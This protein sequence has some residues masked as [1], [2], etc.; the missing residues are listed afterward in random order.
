MQKVRAV[1]LSS[2]LHS[3]DLDDFDDDEDAG[4]PFS[5]PDRIAVTL[6]EDVARDETALAELAPE[7][8]SGEGTRL[9]LFGRGLAI[10]TPRVEATWNSLVAQFGATAKSKRT[11]LILRGFVQGLSARDIG[12]TNALLDKAVSDEILAAWFPELQV[13]APIDQRGVKRLRKSLALGRAPIWQFKYLALGRVSDP[14]PGSD[15]RAL[16]LEMA[17]KDGGFDPASEILYMRYFSDRDQ[18]KA[19]NPALVETGRDLIK[20][21]KF[22]KGSHRDDHRIGSIVEVCFSGADGAAGVEEICVKL[23]R[24]IEERETYGLEY[25]HFLQKL[26]GVQ[27]LASLNGFFNRSEQDQTR[28][29]EMILDVSHHHKSTGFCS[30]RDHACMV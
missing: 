14:I 4:E 16:L 22:T 18:R 27:P 7:L 8:T 17:R 20:D 21:L 5:R 11:A 6:G 13:A 29:C 1:V 10:A 26:F 24:A 3:L 25:D 23:M 15:L 19:I 28:A 9:W 12:L 30:S 2:S